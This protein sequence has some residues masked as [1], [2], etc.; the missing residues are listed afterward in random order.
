MSWK[1]IVGDSWI[2]WFFM[3]LKVDL[4]RHSPIEPLLEIRFF[5]NLLHLRECTLTQPLDQRNQK[6]NSPKW[7]TFTNWFNKVS[8]DLLWVYQ[9]HKSFDCIRV[10]T[11]CQW[12]A[13]PQGWVTLIM[14]QRSTRNLHTIGHLCILGQSGLNTTLITASCCAESPQWPQ[15][16]TDA[17]IEPEIKLPCRN[18]C[19]KS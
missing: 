15:L 13:S 1:E 18:N 6:L 7:V 19:N 2:K 14:T 11:Q 9:M 8:H 5:K 10:W 16:H 17:L 4:L 3:E 12:R